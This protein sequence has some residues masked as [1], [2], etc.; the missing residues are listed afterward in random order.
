MGIQSLDVLHEGGGGPEV[1]DAVHALMGVGVGLLCKPRGRGCQTEAH[2]SRCAEVLAPIPI[3]A[4]KIEAI[5][6]ALK[7]M[8]WKKNLKSKK[9]FKCNVIPKAIT[10]TKRPPLR[11]PKSVAPVGGG[12]SKAF[13]K[14]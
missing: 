14:N 8:F 12:R 3:C 9:L 7:K 10:Q 1:L 11:A 13:S 4:A 6:E 5:V 2:T